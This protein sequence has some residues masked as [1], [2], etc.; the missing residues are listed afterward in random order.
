M[1]VNDSAVPEAVLV[2]GDRIRI[3]QTEMLFLATDQASQVEAIKR[4]RVLTASASE[5]ARQPADDETVARSVPHDLP[6]ATQP[7]HAAEQP[8]RRRRA[9]RASQAR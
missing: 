2:N 6:I 3:G 4:I 7:P 8:R 5:P 9:S 1:T